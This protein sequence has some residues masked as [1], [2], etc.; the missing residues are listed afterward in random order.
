MQFLLENGK[1]WKVS[2]KSSIF[3]D[4]ENVGVFRAIFTRNSRKNEFLSKSN[5][6][7]S[8]ILAL[9]FQFSKIVFIW[10]KYIILQIIKIKFFQD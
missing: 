9:I 1:K 5:F 7:I 3:L 6:W 10:S 8:R 2:P 4:F